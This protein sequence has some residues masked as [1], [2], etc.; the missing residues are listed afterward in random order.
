VYSSKSQKKVVKTPGLADAEVKENVRLIRENWAVVETVMQVAM[1]AFY[2]RLFEIDSSCRPLF[3]RTNYT[4]SSCSLFVCILTVFLNVRADT[5]MSKQ[6]MATGTTI[7]KAVELL[8]DLPTLVPILKALGG[9]HVG[10]GVKAQ[11][12]DSVG[13]ALIDTLSS[14][15]GAAFTPAHKAAWVWVYGIIAS[16]RNHIIFS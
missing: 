7:S 9:R 15:L 8:T 11:H 4:F 2:V 6:A 3:S 5:N 1:D 10:Y 12:Y 16:V 13:Q 14:K